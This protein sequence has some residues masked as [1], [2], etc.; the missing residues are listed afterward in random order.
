M[1]SNIAKLEALTPDRRLRRGV[2]NQ[3]TYLRRHVKLNVV[4]DTLCDISIHGD[5]RVGS[6]CLGTLY[7]V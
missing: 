1:I 4:R 2:P 7:A 6:S 3:V 5:T